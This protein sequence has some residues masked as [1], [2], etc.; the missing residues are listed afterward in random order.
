M[1]ET[2]RDSDQVKIIKLAAFGMITFK[3]SLSIEKVKAEIKS[4]TGCQVP[5]PTQINSK[6]DFSVGWMSPDELA[7]LVDT[8]LVESTIEALSRKL[9]NIHHLCVDVSDSRVAF[10]I[11]GNG[12]R[13]VLAKGTPADISPR[14]FKTGD[15]RRSRIGNLA[16]AFWTVEI[17]SV[18]LMC[19]RSVESFMCDWLE[20][21]SRENS[22]PRFF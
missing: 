20:N 17:N 7:I 1:N 11:V 21:A 8:H 22:I 14:S 5:Q 12:W 9:K 16:A 4:I 3:T 2:S 10:Q 6:K 13:E 19:Y 18:N 15:L